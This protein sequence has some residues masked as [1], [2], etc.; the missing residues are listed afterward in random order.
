MRAAPGTAASATGGLG[1]N[2]AKGLAET[3]ADV[4]NNRLHS[5]REAGSRIIVKDHRVMRR[6]PGRRTVRLAESA[7]VTPIAPQTS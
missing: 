3:L 7:T 6:V 5:D 2:A 1:R 4:A